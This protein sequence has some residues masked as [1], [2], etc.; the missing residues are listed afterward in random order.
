MLSS[1]RLRTTTAIPFGQ[2]DALSLTKM[3][4]NCGFQGL[5]VIWHEHILG[6][7]FRFPAH[8]ARSRIFAKKQMVP[9]EDP[10]FQIIL[11]I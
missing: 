1:A 9:E 10:Q 3:T 11:L 5:V 2:L 8:S 7:C 6:I 4:P